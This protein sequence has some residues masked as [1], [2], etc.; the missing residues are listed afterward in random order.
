MSDPA[1]DPDAIRTM[2]EATLRANWREGVRGTDGARFA[3][4]RP[5]PSRYPFQWYWDS[6]FAAIV[7]RRFDRARARAELESLLCA[8]REDGFIGH[9]I[10]WDTPLNRRQ[11]LTYNV[12]S[13]D[14]SMTSTIQPPLLAWAWSVVVGD[15]AAVPAIA[16]HHDWLAHNRDLEGD[17]LIWIIQPDESGLDASP[18]FDAIWGAQAV[19][20]PGFPL[21][22]RQNRRRGFDLGR[23]VRDGRPA[24]CEVATNVLYALSLLALG[25]PSLTGTI[26][27]RMYDERA[28]LFRPLARPAPRT[29][30][31]VTWA[32][33]SPLALPDLPGEIATRLIEEHLLDAERFWL[34]VPPPSVDARERSFSRR[35][36]TLGIRRY[37]RGPT[38]INSAWLLWMGLERMGYRE[39]ADTMRD[40]IAAAVLRE[41][42][43]EYYDPFDG[44][45]MGARAF[46]WSA[47]AM[48]MVE[49]D[50]LATSSL[51][52]RAAGG[53]PGSDH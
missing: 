21:L 52:A 18:Q 26:V 33:L 25:R 31:A 51:L 34:P 35:E 40:R 9:T 53:G 42:L 2:C 5:S 12:G 6:C 39:H 47:L 22:I 19:G 27:E 4:T 48:E 10:F 36:S 13:P 23:V 20:L 1:V 3:Y 32:A 49:P 45:G 30:P 41:G 16:R 38:W 29:Q 50:P 17:G 37:W 11:R 24:C 43:R 28:G 7:W 8:A 46:A 14:A 44:R 15:P